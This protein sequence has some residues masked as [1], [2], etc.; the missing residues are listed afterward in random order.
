MQTGLA[1]RAGMTRPTNGPRTGRRQR[2]DG[3]E[4]TRRAAGEQAACPRPLGWGYGELLTL[5]LVGVALEV[6]RVVHRV[7]LCDQPFRSIPPGSAPRPDKRTLGNP[8]PALPQMPPGPGAK[9]RPTGH[10]ETWHLFTPPARSFGILGGILEISWPRATT[11][12]DAQD[13]QPWQPCHSK[14]QP[15]QSWPAARLLDSAR[16]GGYPPRIMRPSAPTTSH[17]RPLCALARPVPSF[18]VNVP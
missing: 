2:A 16:V 10:P 9:L 18:P 4:L 11:C 1:Q 12:D 8:A 14:W 15:C 7:G 5:L 17:D 3:N 6:A 13:D